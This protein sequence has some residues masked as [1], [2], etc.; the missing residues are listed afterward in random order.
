M[1]VDVSG[2][3]FRFWRYI[4]FIGGPTC[5]KSAPRCCTNHS[6]ITLPVAFRSC[7]FPSPFFRVEITD[8][9]PSTYADVPARTSARVSLPRAHSAVPMAHGK[10]VIGD[11]HSPRNALK[12]VPPRVLV[13]SF[14]KVLYD[15][16][17]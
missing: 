15:V 1:L 4:M 11:G 2:K 17:F 16:R 14:M 5:G 13:N 9:N 3:I 6:E 10:V 8:W 12:A 7:D